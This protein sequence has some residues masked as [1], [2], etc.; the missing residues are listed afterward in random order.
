MQEVICGTDI[1]T[2]NTSD[3]LSIILYEDLS[4]IIED[5]EIKRR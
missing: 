1:P 4:C 2:K 3:T 5:P